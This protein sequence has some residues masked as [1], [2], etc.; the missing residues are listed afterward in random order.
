[1]SRS[2]LL[3]LALAA[4]PAAHAF[5]L[6]DDF[7]VGPF[8]RRIVGNGSWEFSQFDLDR[9]RVALGERSTALEV[10]GNFFQRPVDLRLGAGETRV[11]SDTDELSSILRFDYGNTR[12]NELDL[13]VETEFWVDLYTE[14]P[15][16]RLA[17]FHTLFVRDRSGLTAT[18]NSWILRD[19]GIRFRRQNF[20]RAVDWSRIDFVSFE[21][22]YTRDSG[23]HPLAYGVQRI[24][25]VPEPGTLGLGLVAAAGLAARH[26]RRR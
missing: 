12:T 10:G 24:Y 17:D 25:A 4:A 20:S 26:R 14:D 6:I 5:V 8:D 22:R 19:G 15:V 2:A 11:S 21:S 23:V 16:G 7:T 1:M 9:S 13:T 18:N 3:A